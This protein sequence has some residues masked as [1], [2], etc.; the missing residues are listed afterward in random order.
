E[1]GYSI[2]NDVTGDGYLIIRTTGKRYEV[3]DEVGNVLFEKDYFSKKPMLIQYYRLG[4]SVEWIAFVDAT[5]QN[6]YI[7][8]SS[9]QLIT[10]G[11]LRSGVPV[12]V[13]QFEN[14]YEI[15][16]AEDKQMS[17]IRIIK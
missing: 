16:L 17:V 13:L 7:Y 14:Y 11:P 1:T 9:G 6:L 12:S 4:G 15:Y 5:D 2:I 10:G 3:L 8:N